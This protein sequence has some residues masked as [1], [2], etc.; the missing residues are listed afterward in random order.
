MDG[1]AI[2]VVEDEPDLADLVMF[3]LSSAGY[4]TVHASNGRVAL[5]KL[6]LGSFDLVLTDVMMPVMDGLQLT[7]AIRER[8]DLSAVP[9]LVCSALSEATVRATNRPFDAF[10]R[11]P[12]LHAQLLDSVTALLVRRDELPV[13]QKCH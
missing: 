13:G 4:V 10:L 2:L 7:Q 9:I 1:R 5:D 12:F 8:K 11:K 6:E 3:V